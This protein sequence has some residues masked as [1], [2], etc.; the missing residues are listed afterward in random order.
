MKHTMTLLLSAFAASAPLSS[1]FACEIGQEIFYCATK[2]K[3]EIRICADPDTAYYTFGKPGARP[4]MAL[5]AA[6]KDLKGFV[7]DGFGRYMT[8]TVEFPNKDI[9]YE[10]YQGSQ[11]PMTEKEV[12]HP[13]TFGGVMVHRNGEQIADIACLPATL[14]GSVS[15]LDVTPTNPR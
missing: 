12:D 3:K 6:R 4:E 13:E 8:D 7:W 1:T 5:S 14:R 11:K 10:V 15:S 9:T 2:N